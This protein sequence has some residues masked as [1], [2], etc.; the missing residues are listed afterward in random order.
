MIEDNVAESRKQY[1]DKFL[2]GEDNIEMIK[3]LVQ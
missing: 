1:F 2:L 3:T